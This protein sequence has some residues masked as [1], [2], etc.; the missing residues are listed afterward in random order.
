[1]SRRCSALFSI[2]LLVSTLVSAAE[3]RPKRI[4]L[5]G[6]SPDNHAWS[7]HEYMA[8]QKLLAQ[9]L[10]RVDGVQ[11]VVVNADEPWAEG[12]ELLDGADGAVV[13]LSQGAQWLS[14]DP[15]RLAAFRKLAERKGGLSVLHWG[16]GTRE[17]PPIDTFVALFG[18]THGGPD[19]KYKVV[20]ARVE[21]AE[22]AITDGIEPFEVKDEFY[23]RLK[24]TKSR[25]G[26]QPLFVVPIEGGDET[27]AWAWD[28]PDGGRSFGFSGLHFHENWSR[29]EYRRLVLQGVL[30]TLDVDRPAKLS[31]DVDASLIETPR[32]KPT[33]P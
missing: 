2:V 19:R 9:M 7:L 28:R 6:Q 16:M 24:F 27:V 29:E 13:F 18:G 23:Y 14:A 11:P 17:V 33:K 20:T 3:P 4:L 22:H 8:G 1:M 32:E 21:P 12:P 26:I 25:P 31:L 15:K 5:L 10:S 30:W